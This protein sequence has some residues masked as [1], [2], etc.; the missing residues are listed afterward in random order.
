LFE[1]DLH[2]RI[3]RTTTMRAIIP[4][5]ALCAVLQASAAMQPGPQAAAANPPGQGMLHAQLVT[6][7]ADGV[8]VAQRANDAAATKSAAAQPASGEEHRPTTAAMLL[9]AVILMTGI[10]L[11]RG[12]AGEQ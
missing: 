11:R 9:A 2:R 3:A 8:I 6:P 10:A 5:I 1:N 12:G 4:A 7:S